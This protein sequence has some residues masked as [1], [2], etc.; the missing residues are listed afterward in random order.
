MGK[1]IETK[2]IKALKWV[3]QFGN[4]SVHPF[5]QKLFGIH[6]LGISPLVDYISST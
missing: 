2:F 4:C 3:N 6:R 5:A 1:I